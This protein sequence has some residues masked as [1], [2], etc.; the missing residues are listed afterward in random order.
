MSDVCARPG[1]SRRHGRG[2]ELDEPVCGPRQAA[3]LDLGFCCPGPG[4]EPSGGWPGSAGSAAAAGLGTRGDVQG[5]HVGRQG[6]R[7]TS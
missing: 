5:A 2:S 4:Q 6:G 7:E 1:P 3:S